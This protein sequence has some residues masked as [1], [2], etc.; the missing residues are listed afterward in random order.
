MPKEYDTFMSSA[1]SMLGLLASEGI[2]PLLRDWTMIELGRET[3]D[4]P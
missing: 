4:V 3:D 1:P 2:K